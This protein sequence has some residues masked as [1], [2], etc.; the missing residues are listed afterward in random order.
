MIAR[1]ANTGRGKVCAPRCS[2]AC[3]VTPGSTTAPKLSP[4][5][6]MLLVVAVGLIDCSARLR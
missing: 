2:M 6:M 4:R 3:P 5:I 1:L